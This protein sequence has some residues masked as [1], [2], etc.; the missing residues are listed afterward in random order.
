MKNPKVLISIII[1]LF[2]IIAVMVMMNIQGT[3]L[4]KF[5]RNYEDCRYI[6]RGIEYDYNEHM[7]KQPEWCRSWWQQLPPEQKKAPEVKAEPAPS[8]PAPDEGDRPES[9]IIKDGA[10]S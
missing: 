9:G 10:G 2:I 7:M 4:S 1:A 3:I 6:M 5:H 8:A